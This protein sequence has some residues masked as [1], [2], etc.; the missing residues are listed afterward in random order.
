[1][2][3]VVKTGVVKKEGP[4]WYYVVTLGKK[5]NGKPNQKKKRGFQ[6]KDDAYK[7][8]NELIY[9]YNK[10]IYV[11]PSSMKF[12]DLLDRW[13]EQKKR[14][15]Q[16]TTFLLY[17]IL[18]N[19]HIIPNLGHYQLSKIKPLI[20][21]DFYNHLYSEKNLSG[22]SVQKIHTVLKDSLNY[23][24]KMELISKNPC[25]SI[26]RPKREYREINVWDLEKTQKFLTS[27]K[28]DPLFI[29]YHIALMTGMRQG[30]I[31]GV[32]WADVDFKKSLIMIRQTRKITGELKA[33]AKSKSGLRV[34]EIGKETI[35]LLIDH[36][37]V[38]EKEKALAGHMY[39]NN[40]LIVCT[41]LGTSINPSNLRRSFNRQIEIAQLNK[42][43]FHDLRHSHA[44]LLL[45]LNTNPKIVAERLGHSD[46]RITLDTYSHLLPNMQSEVVNNISKAVFGNSII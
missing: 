32:R 21:N 7:A 23:A 16:K 24:V 10:G 37:K 25:D 35:E 42:I 11:D 31:L 38:Q 17:D 4:S 33:G 39:E 27:S 8:L 41:S 40:D 22:T 28:E 19:H 6:S 13:S 2:N 45:S 14:S 12:K 1:M 34:V 3:K 29:V 20:I 26:D 9:E 5:L 15:V 18:L 30:E 46:V 44:T 43:R 36:K